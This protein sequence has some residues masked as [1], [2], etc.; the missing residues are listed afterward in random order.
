MVGEKGNFGRMPLTIGSNGSAIVVAGVA[1]LVEVAV[2]Q[3]RPRLV[4]DAQV[5]GRGRGAGGWLLGLKGGLVVH[6]AG[7]AAEDVGDH[8]PRPLGHG[9][10][11][12]VPALQPV[13]VGAPV[14]VAPRVDEPVRQAFHAHS[15]PLHDVLQ[16]VGLEAGHPGQVEATVAVGHRDAATCRHVVVV[17]VM[18]GHHGTRRWF[19]RATATR[20]CL[21]RHPRTRPIP[22]R[23]NLA[24]GDGA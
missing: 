5:P 16:P 7:R 8:E 11:G 22:G 19:L 1:V 9:G 12:R 24:D 6:L 4:P 17:V 10:R 14:I 21:C 20:G 13:V 15:V 2:A 3:R 18:D 23:Q